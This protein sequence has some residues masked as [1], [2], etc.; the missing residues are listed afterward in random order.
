MAQWLPSKKNRTAWS[1]PSYS[2]TS[3]PL[4]IMTLATAFLP[5][6][7]GQIT[8]T[9]LYRQLTTALDF[10]TTLTRPLAKSL[11]EEM[12]AVTFYKDKVFYWI[13]KE[14]IGSC[15][16]L[17]EISST[18]L[19]EVVD[20]LTCMVSN[21]R[22]HINASHDD[23]TVES[24]GLGVSDELI[25]DLCRACHQADDAL[26]WARHTLKV[27]DELV[28]ANHILFECCE[29]WA[30]NRWIDIKANRFEMTMQAHK[31]YLS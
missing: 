3:T 20:V 7:A 25:I 31:G 15:P 6:E 22:S 17:P 23:G 12:E 11:Q 13:Q 21:A 19:R 14:C 29:H 16:E 24:A 27:W 5:I 1:R 30:S 18:A 8:S 26:H 2:T 9:Q 4:N 10:Y 28:Q